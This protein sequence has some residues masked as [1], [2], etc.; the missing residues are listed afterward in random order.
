M[1]HFPSLKRI[2]LTVTLTLHI[3]LIIALAPG[4][5]CGP[6][7]GQGVL[8]PSHVEALGLG[9]HPGLKA[10]SGR[11]VGLQLR[12]QLQLP[13]QLRVGVRLRVGRG[14]NRVMNSEPLY[15]GTTQGRP[16]PPPESSISDMGLR[17][18]WDLRLLTTLRVGLKTSNYA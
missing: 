1:S 11:G 4:C 6:C 14:R 3:T 16:C 2:F 9:P 7:E 15:T 5:L 13:L 8:P 18:G 17:L 10:G 12:L